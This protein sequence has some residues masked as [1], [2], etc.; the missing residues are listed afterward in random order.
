MFYFTPGWVG[1]P[2]GRRPTGEIARR[3]ARFLP[4]ELIRRP[5]G[6]PVGS[7]SPGKSSR[8]VPLLLSWPLLAI[9]LENRGRYSFSRSQK[10]SIFTW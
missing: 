10:G 2:G 4:D 1:E 9:R 7:S 6:E 5:K 3:T 8:P